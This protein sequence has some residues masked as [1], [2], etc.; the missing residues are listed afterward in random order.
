MALRDLGD[1]EK[2]RAPSADQVYMF[3]MFGFAGTRAAAAGPAGESQL[4][5]SGRAAAR[6]LLVR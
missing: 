6:A 5:A 1:V 3:R 2:E 4:A